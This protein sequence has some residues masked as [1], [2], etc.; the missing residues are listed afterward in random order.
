MQKR[1]EE[2]TIISASEV[3]EYVFCAKAWSL[4]R[5]GAVPQSPYIESGVVF[6][7]KHRVQVSRSIFLHR[8]ALFCVSIAII[9]LV[10][11]ALASN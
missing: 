2:S 11:W 10:L 3:A 6:H 8:A 9:L 5:D 1:Q 7:D 4:K